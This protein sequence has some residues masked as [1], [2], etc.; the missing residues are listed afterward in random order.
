MI[1]LVLAPILATLAQK[2][3]SLVGEAVMAKG[4]DWVEKKTGI[5][6]K[7]DMTAEEIIKLEQF[8][9]QNITLLEQIAQENLSKRHEADM[10][11]D[12]WMSKNVRP[13]CLLIITVAIAIGMGVPD[14]YISADRYVAL[15]DM[16]QWVYGYYFCGRSMEKTN[17]MSLVKR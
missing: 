12:S 11:S 15:T 9:M 14:E 13:A 5:E 6:L 16:S 2:G 7:P 1:P 10:K 8:Q 4:K 3:L 17:V